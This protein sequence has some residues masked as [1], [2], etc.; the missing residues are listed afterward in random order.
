MRGDCSSYLIQC[1]YL[2]SIRTYPLLPLFH[3]LISRNVSCAGDVTIVA[4]YKDG[5]D[6]VSVNGVQP[7][8]LENVIEEMIRKL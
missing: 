3:A 2:C 8:S 1:I 7:V 6:M 4:R 5:N